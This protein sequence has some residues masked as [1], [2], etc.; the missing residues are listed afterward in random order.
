MR[1]GIVVRRVPV[2]LYHKIGSAPAGVRNPRSWVTVK[3]FAWQ[4]AHLAR[5]GYRGV[6][7]E[8]V[9]AHY[10]GEALLPKRTVLITFDDGS[11]TVFREAFPIMRDLGLT[12]VAYIVAGRLGGRAHWDRNPA[13]PDD[14]LM[15]P[16]EL[17]RLVEAGW[18]IGAHSMTHPRLTEVSAD[19][20][21]REIEQS[22]L[23]LESTL[24]ISVRSFAYPYGA[25]APIH[26]DLVRK[27][28]YHLAFTTNYSE[29]GLM[30]VQRQTISARAHALR[31][32]WRFRRARRGT[33]RAEAIDLPSSR[34]P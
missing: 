28:G 7:L 5:R 13:H 12:G 30:A 11:K 15:D 9:L 33:F 6:S 3:R 31:F 27:A 24:G 4:M 16:E 10:R 26:A 8:S 23:L 2:L 20:A 22:R 19:E 1:D 25:Y 21:M 18:Q 17:R 32:L 14:D 34:Q 29:Q